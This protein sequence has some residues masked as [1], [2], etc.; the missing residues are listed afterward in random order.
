[1][2]SPFCFNGSSTFAPTRIHGNRLRPY[3]WKT[4]AVPGGGPSTLRPASVTSPAV[5]ASSPPTHFSSVVLPQ[6]DGPTRQTSSP[7]PTVKVR[8]RTASVRRP[9]PS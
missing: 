2:P 6:P 5:G 7:A 9:D 4:N 8:S 3:S 1:M